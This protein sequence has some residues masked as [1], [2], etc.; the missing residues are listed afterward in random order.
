MGLIAEL[1]VL[2][3]PAVVGGPSTSKPRMS[4]VQV[5]IWTD[6]KGRFSDSHLG[7]VAIVNLGTGRAQSFHYDDWVKQ[8]VV[9]L[10]PAPSECGGAAAAPPQGD[11]LGS[12]SP[13]P[14]TQ[15]PDATTS[16]A[17]ALPDEAPHSTGA[18]TRSYVVT[19]WTSDVLFAGT[20]SPV[21]LSLCGPGGKELGGG[22]V[23]LEPT[24]GGFKRDASAVCTVEVPAAQDCGHPL[25][26]ARVFLGS[27]IVRDGWHLDRLEIAC[28]EA[29]C[30]YT[31]ACKQWLDGKHG[32]EK[33]WHRDASAADGAQ[34]TG[35]PGAGARKARAAELGRRRLAQP[36]PRGFVTVH[37]CVCRWQCGPGSNV[38]A[39]EDHFS[40][41]RHRCPTG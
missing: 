37:K 31:F 2:S 12:A 9:E 35:G 3:M 33:A 38:R 6:G 20:G 10:L 14:A 39:G 8:D 27:S 13:E 28:T 17:S 29:Q 11:G 7:S 25:T 23:T 26:S 30:Q 32:R 36:G 5:R 34:E 22:P 16:Q 4:R 24:S 18:I 15:P 19:C 40:G 41:C 21:L 1:A